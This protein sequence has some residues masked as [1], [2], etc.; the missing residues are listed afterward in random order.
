MKPIFLLMML[1]TAST[2]FAVGTDA[3]AVREVS[4]PAF[5]TT[6]KGMVAW[7]SSFVGPRPV[8]YVFPEWWG[9]NGYTRLR[10]KMLAELGYFAVAVDVYGE[11]KQAQT[12]EEAQ[13]LAGPFYAQPGRVGSVLMAAR[14]LASKFPQADVL[15]EAAIGYCFGGTMVLNLMRR[16]EK[17]RAVV[18]FH[19]GLKGQAPK[20]GS[21]VPAAL[22]CHG[23][24]DS[25]VPKK[26]VDAF[27]SDMRQQHI[28]FTLKR[29]ANCT[30]AFT[31]P[32]ATENGKRFNLPIAY[33]EAG[34]LASW[35]DMK[36][37]LA[38]H[39]K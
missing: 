38:A 31:N 20:E 37:F 10:A 30:H 4:Y 21:K 18:A 26:E 28:P 22:V 32:D 24:A 29:Y 8:V 2:A 9:C 12:P 23:E 27:E 34:D 36:V 11:G 19:G 16:A 33:N 1:L 35:N 7:D 13:Q 5:G 6:G 14:S 3:V 17:L 15:R 39:F 25:F